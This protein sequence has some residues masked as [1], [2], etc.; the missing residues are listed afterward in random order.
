MFPKEP[1]IYLMQLNMK[2]THTDV[3][4]TENIVL[5]LPTDL[6]IFYSDICLSALFLNSLSTVVL[7]NF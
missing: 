4:H 2:E 3:Q 7:Q 6:K 1:S 5:L